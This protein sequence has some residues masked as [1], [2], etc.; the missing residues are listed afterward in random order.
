MN[1]A[2]AHYEVKRH[3]DEATKNGQVAGHVLIKHPL[4]FT[5]GSFLLSIARQEILSIRQIGIP[6]RS[7]D[8]AAILT[9]LR[10]GNILLIEDI[11]RLPEMVSVMLIDTMASFT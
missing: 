2:D 8:L 11:H 4:A 10:Q 3:F 1:I 7:G 6:E 9:H 5:P